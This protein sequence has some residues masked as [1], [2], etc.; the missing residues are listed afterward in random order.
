MP[1]NVLYLTLAHLVA[2]IPGRLVVEACD[3]DNDGHAD[4]SVVQELLSRASR[5]VDELLGQRFTVPFRGTFPPIVRGAAVTFAAYRVYR[6]RGI[7][8]DENPMAK[9]RNEMLAKLKAIASGAEPLGPGFERTAPSVSV[10]AEPAKTVS[11]RGK[12]K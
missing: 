8:D 6:R 7:S 3:D 2:D 11:Q 4:P 12:T 9:Q 5:D 10:I 1:K